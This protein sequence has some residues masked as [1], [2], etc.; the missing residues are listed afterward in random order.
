MI[1]KS[2]LQGKPVLLQNL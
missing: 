2:T 1:S